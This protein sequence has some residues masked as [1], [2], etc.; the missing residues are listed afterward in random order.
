MIAI[1][2]YKTAAGEIYGFSADSHGSGIV[3]AAVSILIQN[4][5]N[6]IERFTEDKFECDYIESGGHLEFNHPLIRS[7]GESRDA[8]L[9]LNS[10]AL[11]LHGVR[12]RYK[13]EIV[14][15]TEADND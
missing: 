1:K 15:I 7:G 14:I 9:L 8:S 10:M 12:D 3:C 13:K 4:T 5:V 11:G 6:S 2:I